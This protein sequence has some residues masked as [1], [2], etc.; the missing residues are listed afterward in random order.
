[1]IHVLEWVTNSHGNVA[2]PLRC[3]AHLNYLYCKFTNESY[4]CKNFENQLALC[5]VTEKNSS[6]QFFGSLCRLV[7]IWQRY[8]K[9]YSFYFLRTH[10]IFGTKNPVCEW[11]KLFCWLVCLQEWADY[12]ENAKQAVGIY[13]MRHQ[14]VKG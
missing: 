14:F 8:C 6:V 13:E 5:E 4:Q 1:M 9:N 3:G 2:P 11:R 12:D 10:C 7:K